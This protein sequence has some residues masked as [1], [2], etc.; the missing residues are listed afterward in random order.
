MLSEGPIDFIFINTSIDPKW[1]RPS[2][3]RRFGRQIVWWRNRLKEV[4][5]IVVQS[6]E[7]AIPRQLQRNLIDW[8]EML[9]ELAGGWTA[10]NDILLAMPTYCLEQPLAPS[11]SMVC[12][13][14]QKGELF[15]P[16]KLDKYNVGARLTSQEE[17]ERKWLCLFTHLPELPWGRRFV[18]LEVTEID[19]TKVSAKHEIYSLNGGAFKT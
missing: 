4:C 15:S 2:G 13:G 3:K 11:V 17:S 19:A 14:F 5:Q 8:Y 7:C 6:D 1:K 10:R 18:V 16:Q 12:W 9:I